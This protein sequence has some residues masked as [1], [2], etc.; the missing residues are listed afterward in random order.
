[1]GKIWGNLPGFTAYITVYKF[2][3][4]DTIN[5]PADTNN[6]SHIEPSAWLSPPPTPFTP[7]TFT[8]IRPPP[9]TQ[10]PPITQP[11]PDQVA[12]EWQ[13]F[14]KYWETQAQIQKMNYCTNM[15]IISN[16]GGLKHWD[17]NCGQY[18]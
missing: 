7:P 13:E 16:I 9:I 4:D 1:M 6:N 17:E 8:P 11:S 3:G 5:K 15:A 18:D 12:G 10:R 14:D 2:C